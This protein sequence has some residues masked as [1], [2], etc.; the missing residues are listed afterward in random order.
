VQAQ[1]DLQNSRMQSV[2]KMVHRLGGIAQK[3]QLVSLGAHDGMLTAAVRSGTVIRARQGWYSTLSDQ[4]PALRA[5]KVGGRLTGMSALITRGA[6]AWNDHPLHVSVPRQ[7]G[8]LREQWDRFRRL[9]PAVAQDVIIHWDDD[10]TLAG[11][12]VSS[13]SLTEALRSV[14]LDEPFE[15]AVAAFDWAFKSGSV[16]RMTFERILLTLPDDARMIAHWVDPRCDSILESVVRSWLQI[17]GFHVVSQVTVGDIE[18]IDLVVEDEV[19]IELGGRTHE[20]RRESDWRKNVRITVEG[21]HPILATYSMVRN[22][23]ATILDAIESA[24]RCRHPEWSR[25]GNSGTHVDAAPHGRR[26]WRL[27]DGTQTRLPEFP[28]G[29]LRGIS[30][31]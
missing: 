8:R 24:L 14:V 19:A 1:P 23:F 13:V 12:D 10:A 22:E 6:W 7:A 26:I 18:R 11:G 21:R 17:A 2:R 9:N 5:A 15:L 16:D 3:Q 28:V 30:W 20:G 25:T 29:G 31:R 4:D 27:L